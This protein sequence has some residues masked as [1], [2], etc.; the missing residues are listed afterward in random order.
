MLFMSIYTFGPEKAKEV[1]QRRVEKGPMAPPGMK[2][3]GEWSDLMGGRVFRLF[4]VDNAKVGLAAAGAWN[5][6]GKIE[7]VSVIDTEELVKIVKS[8]PKA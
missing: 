3:H 8:M 2:I 6:L 5:D 4:E 1:R 7:L